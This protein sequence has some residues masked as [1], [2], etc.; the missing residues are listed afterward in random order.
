MYHK[1][2]VDFLC[3]KMLV[4]IFYTTDESMAVKFNGVTIKTTLKVYI[5]GYGEVWF[6]ERAIINILAL[7]KSKIK[8]RFTYDRN[9]DGFFIVHTPS[10]KYVYFN[11]RKG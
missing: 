1:S 6:D 4:T 5:N 3:N 11:I 10:S 8:L 2:T 9:S 7:N